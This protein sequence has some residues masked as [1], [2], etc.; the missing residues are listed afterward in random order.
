VI[1]V[2]TCRD[3]GGGER[4]ESRNSIIFSSS[5]ICKDLK[6]ICVRL[7]QC[8]PLFILFS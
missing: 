3:L 5:L 4:K 6:M 1:E 2:F 8:P 7:P